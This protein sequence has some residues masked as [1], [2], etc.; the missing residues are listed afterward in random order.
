MFL[1]FFSKF[2]IVD[3]MELFIFFYFFVKKACVCGISNSWV[4]FE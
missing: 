3:L 2:K 4:L 1:G